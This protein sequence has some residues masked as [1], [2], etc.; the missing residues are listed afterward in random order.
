[1]LLSILL[2]TQVSV[3]DVDRNPINFE[4]GMGFS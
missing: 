3:G 2:T 1:M 4:D